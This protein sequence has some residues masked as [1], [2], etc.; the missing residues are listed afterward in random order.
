MTFNDSVDGGSDANGNKRVYTLIF[1]ILLSQGMRFT[2]ILFFF[3][4]G[5]ITP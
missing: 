3:N 1:L 4:T 5:D 2:F